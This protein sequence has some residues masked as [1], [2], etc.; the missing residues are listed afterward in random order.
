M[1]IELVRFR[2]VDNGEDFIVLFSRSERGWYVTVY[3]LSVDDGDVFRFFFNSTEDP[4]PEDAFWYC[5]VYKNI[6]RM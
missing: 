1:K 2:L 6:I 5:S 4:K 3:T